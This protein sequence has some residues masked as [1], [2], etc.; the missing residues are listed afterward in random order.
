MT[1]IRVS[2]IPAGATP[3]AQRFA[4]DEAVYVLE[5]RGLT[6]IWVEGGAKRSFRRLDHGSELRSRPPIKN[7]VE[8]LANGRELRGARHHRNEDS[9]VGPRTGLDDR[10]ELRRQSA[11]R[12]QQQVDAARGGAA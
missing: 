11:R 5:G 6:T 9:Q 2:E 12:F 1:E 10:G 7:A 3:P 4:F 8:R